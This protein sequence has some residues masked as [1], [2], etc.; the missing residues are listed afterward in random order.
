IPTAITFVAWRVLAI[1]H[2]A[3]RDMLQGEP[4]N[5]RWYLVAAFAFTVA[6][7]LEVQ[8]RVA[9]RASALELAVPAM[10]V[11]GVLGFI[12]A[13]TLPGG[14][15]LVAWPFFAATMAASWWRRS[16]RR[17]TSP[18]PLVALLAWP[19]LLLWPPLLVALE[20]GLTIKVLAFC[21]A[22]LALSLAMIS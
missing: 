2:P 11:W 3:Y 8:R 1:A 21:V 7:V 15:Y 14:T 9:A 6:I 5:A 10:F 16:A 19:V 22:L 20:V 18:S 4:Y 12:L 13:K 17:N